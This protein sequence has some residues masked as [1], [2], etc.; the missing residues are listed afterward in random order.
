MRKKQVHQAKCGKRESYER[1]SAREMN[2]KLTEALK[3][4]GEQPINYRRARDRMVKELRHEKA[5]KNPG[6]RADH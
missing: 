2:Q 4:M 6:Q 1:G 3:R 5:L